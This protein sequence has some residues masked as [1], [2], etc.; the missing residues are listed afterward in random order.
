M[1]QQPGGDLFTQRS[2]VARNSR[3]VRLGEPA[4]G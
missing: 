1:I 2:R 3:E 4:K